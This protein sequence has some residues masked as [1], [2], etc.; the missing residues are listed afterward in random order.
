METNDPVEVLRNLDGRSTSLELLDSFANGGDYLLK[1][2]VVD[3]VCE[4][5][6][7]KLKRHLAK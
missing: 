2:R 6:E 4:V 3:E 7:L 1:E 5:V